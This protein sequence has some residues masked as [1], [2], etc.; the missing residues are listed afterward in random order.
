M[1]DIFGT[2]IV[3]SFAIIISIILAFNLDRLHN[4]VL[5][6]TALLEKQTIILDKLKLSQFEVIFKGGTLIINE[7]GKDKEEQ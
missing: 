3:L 1:K 7:S 5:K 6:Q 2:I 4:A